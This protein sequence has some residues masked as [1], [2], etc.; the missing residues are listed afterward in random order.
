MN[1]S[2]FGLSVLLFVAYSFAANADIA[3]LRRV[4][5]ALSLP[6]AEK[7]E[8]F[9]AS[10]P[11]VIVQKNQVFLAVNSKMNTPVIRADSLPKGDEWLRNVDWRLAGLSEVLGEWLDQSKLKEGMRLNVFSERPMSSEVMKRVRY[12]LEDLEFALAVVKTSSQGYVVE[13]LPPPKDTNASALGGLAGTKIDTAKSSQGGAVTRT[14]I[15]GSLPK[16]SIRKTIRGLMPRIRF[17]YEKELATQPDIH[18]KVVV[19][20]VILPTGRLR[21]PQMVENTL[22]N[23]NIGKCMKRVLRSAQFPKPKGGGIVVVT[24]PFV[25]KFK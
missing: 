16:E 22:H 10:N 7:G 5:A 24:Y 4:V 18:G 15:M 17:C 19:K 11:A 6:K 9:Q 1:R 23:E 2:R 3:T 20:F 12:T 13:K 8:T 21:K 14:V 25:F